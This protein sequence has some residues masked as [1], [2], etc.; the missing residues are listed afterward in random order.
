MQCTSCNEI[1]EQ[2]EEIFAVLGRGYLMCKSL[3]SLHFAMHSERRIRFWN[4]RV[5]VMHQL[6]SL[7]KRTVNTLKETRAVLPDLRKS[8]VL[9]SKQQLQSPVEIN[10]ADEC[11]DLYDQAM[12]ILLTNVG[13][14][15]AQNP[16]I[17]QHVSY[18]KKLRQYRVELSKV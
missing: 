2:N 11:H 3:S 17:K 8:V 7:H 9:L 4:N 12:A 18:M 6:S 10:D 5:D 16:F 14:K 13:G 1:G 15:R